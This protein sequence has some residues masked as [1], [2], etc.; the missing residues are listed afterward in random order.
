MVLQKY[1]PIAGKTEHELMLNVFVNDMVQSLIDANEGIGNFSDFEGLVLRG[2]GQ[3]LLQYTN[4]TQIDINNKMAVYNS[5]I[6]NPANVSPNF[7]SCP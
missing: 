4:Y 6:S 7:V 1:G 3:D 2:F 5:F